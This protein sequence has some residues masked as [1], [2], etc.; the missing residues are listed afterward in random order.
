MADPEKVPDGLLD[1]GNVVDGVIAAARFR[2]HASALII[3]AEVMNY[4][5]GLD[6][7]LKETAICV[8]DAKGMIVAEGAVPSDPASILDWFGRRPFQISQAGLDI[9]GSPRVSSPT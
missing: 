5:A 9:G 4:Y 7:S 8:V 2:S 1:G 3:M 6:V